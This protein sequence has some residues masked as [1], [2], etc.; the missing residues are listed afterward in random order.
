MVGKKHWTPHE[1]QILKEHYAY[2]GNHELQEALMLRTTGAIRLQGSRMGLKK[3]HDRLR[4]M[5][6]ENI[7]LRAD[8][9]SK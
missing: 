6:R 5:G 7:A 8:R 3:A 4:E 1:K 9:T 2:I